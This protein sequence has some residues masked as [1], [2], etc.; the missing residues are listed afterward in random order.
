MKK[1]ILLTSTLSL[2][3]ACSVF[4]GQPIDQKVIQDGFNYHS[5]SPV[6]RPTASRPQAR[7]QYN[8]QTQPASPARR[9]LAPSSQS[10]KDIDF[11]DKMAEE[12]KALS[13]EEIAERA[14]Q[15]GYS[16]PLLAPNKMQGT[17]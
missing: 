1:I 7:P 11:A 16:N 4:E 10:Q 12:F 13:D 3:S 2:I 9:H 6:V 5:S 17:Q 14:F 8:Y 15:D